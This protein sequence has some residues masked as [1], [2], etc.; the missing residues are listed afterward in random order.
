MAEFTELEETEEIL[1]CQW[2]PK[3]ETTLQCYQCG[4]P[5]CVKC[6]QRTP[7]GYI[8]PLCYKGRRQRFNQA[9]RTDYLIAAGVSF[10]LGLVASILPL[11]GWFVIFL[12]PLAGGLIAEIVWRLVGRRYSEHL[13]WIV[14]AGIA[15]GALPVF[16]LSLVPGIFSLGLGGEIT[17][18]LV[19]YGLLGLLWPIVHVALAVGAAAARLRL[20]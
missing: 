1:H 20:S 2:H 7:V 18:A 8:C 15:L 11:V 10:I 17:G 9:R 19:A 4:T 6:A 14:G 12:S 16:L 5:I 3:V 13:W